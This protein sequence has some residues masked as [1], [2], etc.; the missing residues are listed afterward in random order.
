MVEQSD[1]GMQAGRKANSYRV[2]ICFVYA[3]VYVLYM[4]C[5][6][7]LYAESMLGLS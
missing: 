6:S 1:E 5:I 3:R 4:L 7:I 2:C